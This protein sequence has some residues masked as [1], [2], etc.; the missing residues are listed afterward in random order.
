MVLFLYV[1]MMLNL[2]KIDDDRKAAWSKIL[3]VVAAGV[4]LLVLVSALR[5]TDELNHITQTSGSSEIGY[6]QNLG[7]VLFKECLV[8]FELASVLF[9]GAMVGAVYLSKKDDTQPINK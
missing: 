6:T 5:R 4:L 1:I 8:P 9:L 2:N 7:I 3:S